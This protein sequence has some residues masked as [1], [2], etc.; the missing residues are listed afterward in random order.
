M[1]ISL[2]MNSYVA[3]S[4]SPSLLTSTTIFE[5]SYLKNP[6][7]EASCERNDANILLQVADEFIKSNFYTFGKDPKD[8]IAKW[9]NISLIVLTGLLIAFKI[10]KL[11]IRRQ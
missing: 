2:T 7:N 4:L 5:S 9:V 1:P 10:I 11:T 3:F 6:V 8:V